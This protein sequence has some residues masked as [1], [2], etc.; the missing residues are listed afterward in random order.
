KEPKDY[1]SDSVGYSNEAVDGD[2][3]SSSEN[4]GV[5][6]FIDNEAME[7]NGE[8]SMDEEERRYIEENQIPEDGIS[9][10]SESDA[11]SSDGNGSGDDLELEYECNKPK[12]SN[13]KRRSHLIFDSSDE[14]SENPRKSSRRSSVIGPATP[15]AIKKAKIVIIESDDE[16][17]KMT[18]N[19]GEDELANLDAEPIRNQRS[20][21]LSE[22]N[23]LPK[24]EKK[25]LSLHPN[26]KL[27][28]LESNVVGQV[29]G[30]TQKRGGD[31]SSKENIEEE[32]ENLDDEPKK[33]LQSRR[34][35]ESV[36]TSKKGSKRLSL[37]PNT[38]LASA[39]VTMGREASSTE[40]NLSTSLGQSSKQD[41]TEQISN[42]ETE[43]SINIINS[44]RL[45]DSSSASQNDEKRLSLHPNTKP[46]HN[47]TPKLNVT[48]QTNVNNTKRIARSCAPGSSLISAKV[49][50]RCRAYL[51]KTEEAKRAEKL[52]NNLLPEDKY[53]KLKEKKA[54]KLKKK[55]EKETRRLEMEAL[56]AEKRQLKLDK[57]SKMAEITEEETRKAIAKALA[58][59]QVILKEK[60]KHSK[61]AEE[62]SQEKVVKTEVK[63]PAKKR[64]ML[65]ILEEAPNVKKKMKLS[66]NVQLPAKP[67][68]FTTNSVQ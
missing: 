6:S 42:H 33:P 7:S 67:E 1:N 59:S 65:Q 34:L 58:F 61:V 60:H 54:A 68:G 63:A 5:M 40:N 39:D 57:K 53:L 38:K 14:E 2:E 3:E 23:S 48:E 64:K 62:S 12:T 18:E 29:S 10:G 11:V 47:S 37:H 56:A 45:S 36:S 30:T 22:S 50:E 27:S 17:N 49:I 51:E 43:P 4:E 55:Q 8:S 28:S 35:S 9:L 26:T 46:E 32:L 66:E 41:T 31:D 52:K 44:K 19:I 13:K 24:T 16:S 25:R 15:I 20:K 21:R